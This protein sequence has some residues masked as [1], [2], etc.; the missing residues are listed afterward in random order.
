MKTTSYP[1]T[2][3]PPS[4]SRILPANFPLPDEDHKLMK[5][6]IYIGD[7]LDRLWDCYMTYCKL[8][9][10]P[11]ASKIFEIIFTEM[12]FFE[13]LRGRILDEMSLPFRTQVR[14]EFII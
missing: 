3:V 1:P 5:M 4:P 11:E 7:Y 14:H 9:S 6:Y 2:G 10:R 13:I 12:D 8:V